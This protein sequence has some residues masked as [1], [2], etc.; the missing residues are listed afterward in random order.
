[1]SPPAGAACLRI[2][3]AGTAA[4]CAGLFRQVNQAENLLL[5]AGLVGNAAAGLA[6]ALAGGLAFAAAAVLNAFF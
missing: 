2:Q 5:L 3:N 6:G 4:A 1:M